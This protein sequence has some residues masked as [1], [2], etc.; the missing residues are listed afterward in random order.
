M[1]FTRRQIYDLVWSKPLNKLATEFGLSDQGLAKACKRYDVPVPPVGYWQKLAYGKRVEHPPLGSDKFDDDAIVE[2]TTGVKMRPATIVRSDLEKRGPEPTQEIEPKTNKPDRLHSM[3]S[4][5]KKGFDKAKDPDDFAYINVAPFKIRASP[6]QSD[7]VI[8]LIADI[9]AAASFENWEIK[10]SKDGEW[11]LLASEERIEL[12]INENTRKVAHIPTPA[13]IRDNQ[14]YS[15]NKIPEFDYLPSGEL[16]F[17]IS[18]G[19]YLGVRTNWSDGK[20]QTLESVLPGMIE[21]ISIVGA[22]RYNRRLEREEQERQWELQ[23]QREA[24]RRR[25][26]EIQRTRF[27]VFKEQAKRHKEAEMLR[28]YVGQ[29]KQKLG[30]LAQDDRSKVQ[31]WI[32]WA[33]KSIEDL[34]PLNSGLPVLVSEEEA[35]RNSWRYRDQ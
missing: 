27:A 31:T 16:K 4:K 14:R 21:G 17:T 34:D 6:L 13:E 10:T 3:L 2:V 24:E 26:E 1:Q 5:I 7:R 12:A 35:S 29:V 11:E 30:E 18:N 33:E 15:W 9:L 28:A 32:E 19:S 25:L 8:A 22:A 23:R 20:K